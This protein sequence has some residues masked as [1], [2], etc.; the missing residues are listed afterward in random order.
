M[1][2]SVRIVAAS[3]VVNDTSVEIRS[4]DEE[5]NETWH[6]IS[7]FVSRIQWDVK[8]GDINM[9][10]IALLPAEVHI[11]AELD[12][13]TCDAFAR[14]LR[15]R[16]WTVVAPDQQVDVTTFGDKVR[17]YAD[18]DVTTL[19]ALDSEDRSVKGRTL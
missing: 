5:G 2:P 15:Y 7:D 17:R 16:G 10:T 14:H 9:V 11:E 1:R 19:P 3:N 12:D 8:A 18:F 4:E 6:Q 13:R